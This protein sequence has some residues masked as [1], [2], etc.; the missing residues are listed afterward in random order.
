ME[1]EI[2]QHGRKDMFTEECLEFITSLFYINLSYATRSLQAVDLNL[3]AVFMVW[4]FK[5]QKNL[6]GA[7]ANC[8]ARQMQWRTWD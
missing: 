6:Q 8:D 7:M 4:S 5:T 1:G 2:T 3:E